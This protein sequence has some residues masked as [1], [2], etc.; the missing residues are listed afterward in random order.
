MSG[1]KTQ[2]CNEGEQH[3]ENAERNPVHIVHGNLPVVWS[4]VLVL[5]AARLAPSGVQVGLPA[6]LVLGAARLAPSGP[7]PFAVP[8]SR[9]PWVAIHG[10]PCDAC[11]APL[12]AF[13]SAFRPT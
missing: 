9:K 11:V 3:H 13:K 12:R 8:A 2:P 1:G 7:L 10:H 5:G 6:D 4:F